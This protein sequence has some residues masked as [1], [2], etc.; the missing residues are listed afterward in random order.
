MGLWRTH[1]GAEHPY[2][3]R[4]YQASSGISPWLAK[5]H[6]QK[7]FPLSNYQPM[8]PFP[9]APPKPKGISFPAV[10]GI[11]AAALV[12]GYLLG[13]AGGSSSAELEAAKQRVSQLETQ[14]ATQSAPATAA[15]STAAPTVA[16]K[17]VAPKTQAAAAPAVTLSGDG[18]MKSK[19]V[20]LEGDY[21]ISWKTLG[22]CYYSADLENG[23]AWGESVFTA[24][25][26]PHSGTS[27]VYGLDATDYYLD[28]ITGPAPSCG[29]S[30]TL[31]PIP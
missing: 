29:W 13:G 26:R 3:E 28:V 15:E 9:P 10:L 24:S 11:G 19:K 22:A 16:P 20:P 25:D 4:I 27:N 18:K 23:G 1:V 17:T 21:S 7:G 2:T 12:F 5:G 8:R 14:L 6:V 30:V 31:T